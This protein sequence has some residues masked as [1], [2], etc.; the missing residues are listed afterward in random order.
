[1]IDSKVDS[2]T[3]L[4]QSGQG[5]DGG[6]GVFLTGVGPRIPFSQSGGLIGNLDP[7]SYPLRL[8]ERQDQELSNLAPPI[9]SGMGNEAVVTENPPQENSSFSQ[10][11]SQMVVRDPVPASGPEAWRF[12]SGKFKA[13]RQ[14]PWG[15]LAAC[16]VEGS[17][18][19]VVS[20]SQGAS[21]AEI[22]RK[23]RSQLFSFGQ[24]ALHWASFQSNRDVWVGNMRLEAHNMWQ[25]GK[26]LG[27]KKIGPDMQMVSNLMELEVRDNGVW[28]K[29]NEQE[30]RGDS[31]VA[32]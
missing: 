31:N 8:L 12:S 10:L 24:S 3:Q 30:V 20:K 17:R 9:N 15:S 2:R 22:R 16:S 1:M 23:V 29:P 27:V 26:E 25:L 13:L 18:Q 14:R 21:V 4:G 7:G 28:K 5:S 32:Q 19:P 6:P 11:F